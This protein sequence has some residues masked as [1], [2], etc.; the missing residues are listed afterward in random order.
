MA[1]DACIAGVFEKIDKDLIT[2][3]KTS[4]I[5]PKL[6]TLMPILRGLTRLSDPTLLAKPV[7][8]HPSEA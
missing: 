1:E 4:T 7:H 8:S 5:K 3:L 6:Q 2:I